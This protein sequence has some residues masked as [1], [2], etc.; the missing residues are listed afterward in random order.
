MVLGLDL[1][2]GR[3]NGSSA[4]HGQRRERGGLSPPTDGETEPGAP[5]QPT[6]AEGGRRR[7]GPSIRRLGSRVWLLPCTWHRTPAGG[8][9]RWASWAL[10]GPRCQDPVAPAQQTPR[11]ARSSHLARPPCQNF[12]AP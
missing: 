4:A 7:A 5:G 11:K 8:R 2:P 3:S 1:A 6:A 12:R 10:D 9:V